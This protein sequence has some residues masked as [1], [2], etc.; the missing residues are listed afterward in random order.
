[1]FKSLMSSSQKFMTEINSGKFINATDIE[2]S[3]IAMTMKSYF[4]FHTNIFTMII[5]I[6]V[7]LLTAPVP[8]LL[9]V[10]YDISSVYNRK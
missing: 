8:T 6:T 10:F 3:M 2:P 4:T 1:M 7:L 5:Y 9:G